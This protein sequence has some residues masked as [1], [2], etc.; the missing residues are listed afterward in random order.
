VGPLL[1]VFLCLRKEQFSIAQN[2]SI[3][4]ISILPTPVQ[5]SVV[6]LSWYEKSWKHADLQGLNNTWNDSTQANS[7]VPVLSN[8]FPYGTQPIK[9]ISL[10][11]WLILEV[12][13]IDT[14]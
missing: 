4:L 14:S 6:Y 8:A 9:G 5:L 1:W 10:G 7:N 2:G 3:G 11:G 13:R 12:L